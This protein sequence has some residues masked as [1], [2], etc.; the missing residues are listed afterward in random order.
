[1][2]VDKDLLNLR[3]SICLS[4]TDSSTPTCTYESGSCSAGKT[5]VASISSITNAHVSQCSGAGSY[6][7]KVCCGFDTEN[8]FPGCNINSYQITPNC[9]GGEDP[10]CETG[11]KI[12][13]QV[14]YDKVNCPNPVY[15]QIDAANTDCSIG[16][17]TRDDIR[18]ITS[19]CRVQTIGWWLF[20]KR[21]IICDPWTIPQIPEACSED[22][23]TSNKVSLY[24]DSNYRNLINNLE[25]IDGR[26][27][28]TSSSI[29]PPLCASFNEA[30]NGIQCCPGTGLICNNNICRCPE[31]FFWNSETKS[32]EAL[33]VECSLN[34]AYF[35]ETQGSSNPGNFLVDDED[36]VYINVKGNNPT[37]C[38]GQTVTLTYWD[39][40][41]TTHETINDPG[42]LGLLP[43]LTFTNDLASTTW[44]A[45]WFDDNNDPADN[46]NF[47]DYQFKAKLGLISEK[48]SNILEVSD[49]TSGSEDI[50]SERQSGATCQDCS[51]RGLECIDELGRFE[52]SDRCCLCGL[53]QDF[54]DG[55]SSTKTYGEC[56]DDGNDDQYGTV[57]VTIKLY[58]QNGNLIS[59][60]IETEQCTL[61]KDVPVPFFGLINLLIVVVLIA[62]YYILKRK[63]YV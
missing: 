60:S 24:S 1:L 43:T 32:C 35:S 25:R 49:E 46:D 63:E 29:I 15:A 21:V 2:G 55:T 12:N 37:S 36:Q 48:E 18:G 3:W 16:L 56:I 4:S 44:N 30:C 33:E 57:E 27:T 6:D 11:E 5:C 52:C 14:D 50:C 9:A 7:T 20:K 38:N 47:P 41:G 34:S 17:A 59:Q 61:I 53:R 26:F 23:V 22:T 13:I 45:Q 42:S 10:D 8:P 62:I 54:D 51:L 31:R 40:D 58:D 19:T 28:F 39:V